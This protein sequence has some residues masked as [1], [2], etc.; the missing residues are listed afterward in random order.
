MQPATNLSPDLRTLPLPNPNETGLPSS[1]TRPKFKY[2]CFMN[3][4]YVHKIEM[5]LLEELGKSQ[6]LARRTVS[7]SKMLH[8]YL[9]F[10][11]KSRTA[12]YLNC[13]LHFVRTWVSRWE[14]SAS[15]RAEV[16]AAHDSG[17]STLGEYKRFLIALLGDEPRS[18]HPPT[19]T[20][21]Q[22]SQIVA[23]SLSSPSEFDLPFTHWTH[24]SLR[25]EVVRRGIAAKISSRHI[26]RILKKSA[27]ASS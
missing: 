9:V 23:L 7:R 14:S 16:A 13:S 3:K 18:G 8:H 20:E 26:G 10:G 11:N 4:E 24:E 17:E 25:N 5:V 15:L 2:L 27:I 6:K 21:A 1:T 22:R 12:R 19:F